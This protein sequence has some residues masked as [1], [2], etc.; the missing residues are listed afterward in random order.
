M[1]LLLLTDDAVGFRSSNNL[2]EIITRD[3]SSDG[4]ANLFR[5]CIE[6]DEI[7]EQNNADS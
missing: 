7:E 6:N 2:I 1:D 5:L 3:L 4:K